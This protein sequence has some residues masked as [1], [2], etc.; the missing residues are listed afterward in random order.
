FF[1]QRIRDEAHRYV[2]TYHRKRR[3]KTYRRSILEG[4]SG[5]GETRK[6][7]LLKHFGSLKRIKA[8]SVEELAAVQGMTSQ[9]ARAVFK[10]LHCNP[11]SS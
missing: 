1:L 10:I 3:M 11:R 6:T 8:A 4:I 5:I 9:A 2:I 7:R